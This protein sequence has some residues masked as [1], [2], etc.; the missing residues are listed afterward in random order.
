ML[1]LSVTGLDK[2]TSA[3]R[4]L[5]PEVHPNHL[6]TPLVSVLIVSLVISMENNRYVAFI[7]FVVALMYLLVIF[8]GKH[9]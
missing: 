1:G 9:Y 2:R 8:Q 7:C 5:H 4:T 3:Q 6:Q